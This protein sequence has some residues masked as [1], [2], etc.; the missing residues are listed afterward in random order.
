LFIRKFGVKIDGGFELTIPEKW[1]EYIGANA[2]VVVVPDPPNHQVKY[3]L[4]LNRVVNGEWKH[5]ESKSGPVDG[6]GGL[7]QHPEENESGAA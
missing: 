3:Q 1:I 4:F 6:E 7:V 2:Q 5:V